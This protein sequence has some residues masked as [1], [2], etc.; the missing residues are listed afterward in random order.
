ME[1][2]KKWFSSIEEDLKSNNKK[3]V[4]IGGASCSGKSVSTG[5]FKSYLE[6]QGKKVLYIEADKYYKSMSTVLTEKTLKNPMFKKYLPVKDQISKKVKQCTEPYTIENK[7]NQTNIYNL[8]N[9]LSG[10]IDN[11][12]LMPFIMELKDHCKHYNFDEPFVVDLNLLANHIN[13]LN[14]GETIYMP[15]YSM[16]TSETSISNE[17]FNGNDYDYVLIEGLYALRDEVLSK[18]DMSKVATAC[19]KCP[20][21]TM[22]ARRLH[23][24]IKTARVGSSPER[25]II[26]ALKDVLPSYYKDIEPT[27]KRA[28]HILN[29]QLT[30][31][32]INNREKSRQSK[33]TFN[34]EDAR[35]WEK[36]DL[37]EL[38]KPTYQTDHYF[39][40]NTNNSK[41]TLRLRIE[42]E[43]ASELSFKIGNDTT[44]R[45]VENYDLTKIFSEENRDPNYLMKLFNIGGFERLFTVYKIRRYGKLKNYN[46]NIDIRLDTSNFGFVLEIS[47]AT[48][49]EEEY[50]ANLLH[51]KRIDKNI[52]YETMYHEH[53]KTYP[54]YSTM[55]DNIFQKNL[56]DYNA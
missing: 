54:N 15:A 21:K 56:G 48:P 26:S 14:N 10:L 38:T 55:I 45:R 39:K 11:D 17:H 7:F 3:F 8:Y 31:Q 44:D 19:I 51:L 25:T 52:S 9:S 18:I 42:N 20:P 41:L 50:I 12:D 53:I 43:K 4:I 23:R 46:K 36:L 5:F 40:D 29:T 13:L 16:K 37:I 22:F 1:N 32:E 33:F 2:L 24:D 30:D 47:N 28:E 27:F 34:L 49:D 35:K 6:N